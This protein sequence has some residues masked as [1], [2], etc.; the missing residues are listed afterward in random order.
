LIALQSDEDEPVVSHPAHKFVYEKKA[1]EKPTSGVKQNFETESAAEILRACQGKYSCNGEIER[2]SKI[3]VA[4][5]TRRDK[6]QKQREVLKRRGQWN[7]QMQVK[8]EDVVNAATKARG[9]ASGAVQYNEIK[10]NDNQFYYA[11]AAVFSVK[12]MPFSLFVSDF[13]AEFVDNVEFR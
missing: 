7:P 11:D 1:A 13:R 6:A 5:G 9:D 10:L 8:Y 2:L 12:T 4:S 3:I